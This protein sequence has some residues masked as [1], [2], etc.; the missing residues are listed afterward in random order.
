MDS[1]IFLFKRLFEHKT[2]IAVFIA[3]LQGFYLLG[4]TEVSAAESI[5]VIENGSNKLIVY[6]D[7]PGLMPSNKYSIR[8]RS[9]ASNNEWVDCFAHYTYNRASELPDD[10]VVMPTTNFHYQIFTDKWSQT[11]ANFEMS[12]NSLVEVE[13]SLING[14]KVQGKDLAKAVA[15]PAHSVVAQPTLKDGKIYFTVNHPGQIIIDINGQM[16]DFNKAVDDSES[17]SYV[18]HTVAIFANP[19]IKKPSLTGSRVKYITVGTD[20]AT[21]RNINPSSF[22]TLYFM[23]GVHSIG[24]NVKVYPGKKYFI[25]GDAIVYGSFNN[26]GVP[27]GI[28][29]TNGED[30]KIYGYGTIS[31]SK[32]THPNYL[33]GS[34]DHTEFKTLTI[35]NGMNVEIMGVTII[36]PANHSVNFNAWGSRPDKM[37]EVTFARWVKIISWRANGDGI[38][39]SHLVED[40][41]LHTSDDASYIKGNRRRIV[42]WKDANAAMFHMGGM[43]EKGSIFPMVIEDCDV[44]Y[45]RTRGV[46][47]GGVFVQRSEGDP[48]QRIVDVTVRDFRVTDPRSN[49]PTFYL[50]STKI[51]AGIEIIATSYSGLTFQNVTVTA[52]I[53]GGRKNEIIGHVQAPWYGGITFDNVT[54]AGK[55]LTETTFVTEFTKNQFVK[56]IIFKNSAN[57]S[58]IINNSENGSIISNPSLSNYIDNT[59]VTLTATPKPG[60]EFKGW[61]GDVS[62]TIN[63]L[64]ILMKS[65]MTVSANFQRATSFVFE[66]SGTGSWT[67]PDGVNSI[68]LKSWGGGGAGGSAS[69]GTAIVNTQVRGGGGAGGSYAGVTM[70]VTPG[71]VINY[72]V[73]SGGIGAVPGFANQSVGESGGTTF[74]SLNNVTIVSALGGPGGVNMSLTNQI[75]S[76]TGGV[77]PTAGN[78]GIVIYYGGNGGT[79]SSTGTGGGGGSAGAEGNGG[80]GGASMAGNGGVGGGAVGGVGHNSSLPGNSGGTPGDGGSGAAVRNNTPFADNNVSKTGGSGGNGKLVIILDQGTASLVLPSES[81][82][83]ITVYPNPASD[84]LYIKADGN[85]IIKIQLIDLS[86]KVIYT[87]NNVTQHETIDLS[88]FISGLYFVLVHT[89]DNIFREKVIIN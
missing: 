33:P 27:D 44:I 16:D 51:E 8:V 61:S 76:G 14:F 52:P 50:T 36:D 45:N 23:P 62:G 35:E 71:Q 84:K 70:K 89:N 83:S 57:Y 88:R 74:A 37:K 43:P 65:N 41:Y 39:S 5:K 19:I 3:F 64:S 59:A 22:D 66:T 53:V 63:P 2:S 13:I 28:Y 73:G 60:Y 4:A 40:C 81:K 68:T 54:L 6:S 1:L 48:G 47:G 67:V 15:H 18:T 21:I 85:T 42:F 49:M 25:P 86:G 78:T 9:A 82:N 69:C 10:G 24:R 38:G 17:K 87:N 11:Y 20:S 56:D 72:T 58:L 7:V 79:G 29:R 55:L 12:N 32:I 31:G 75:L 77:A 80:N 34:P 30:I 26:Y 46:S